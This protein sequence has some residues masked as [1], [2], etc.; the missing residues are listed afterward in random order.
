MKNSSGAE[1][2]TLEVREVAL[3]SGANL[4][5]IVP[6]EAI[7]SLQRFWVGW[8]YQEYTKKATD[9]MADEVR[10]YDWL[11]CVG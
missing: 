9:I 10:C 2:F 4:L 7:D 6:A 3:D 8:K 11:S 5:G 1:K